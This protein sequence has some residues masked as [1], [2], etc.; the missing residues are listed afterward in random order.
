MHAKKT[1]DC[2]SC[3]ALRMFSGSDVRR[4]LRM[5]A[6]QNRK[7]LFCAASKLCKYSFKKHKALVVL[8]RKQSVSEMLIQ[9]NPLMMPA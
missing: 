8:E 1:K 7:I 4:A 2:L 6:K 5:P 9:L 3:A